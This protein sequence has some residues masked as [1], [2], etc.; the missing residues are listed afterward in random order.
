MLRS[1]KSEVLIFSWG[2]LDVNQYLI[3]DQKSLNVKESLNNSALNSAL[4]VYLFFLQ[5]V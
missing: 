2:V 4:E 3:K 5:K 1:S